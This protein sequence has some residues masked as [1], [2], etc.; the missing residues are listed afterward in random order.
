M[1]EGEEDALRVTR[2]SPIDSTTSE[3]C[4]RVSP[5][6][7]DKPEERTAA[8]LFLGIYSR[9]RLSLALFSREIK[10]ARGKERE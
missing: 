10:R 9:P 7:F 1:R 5:L 2:V 8:H 6:P 4:V 3:T